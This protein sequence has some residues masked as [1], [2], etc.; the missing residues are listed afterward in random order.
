M[1]H[2]KVKPVRIP[3]LEE[4][5]KERE[6]L[7]YKERYHKVFRST[8]YSLVVVAAIAVLLATLFLPVLK[9]SGDSMAPTLTDQDI[10]LLIKTNHYD[11][12]DLCSFSWQNKLLV[13]R[14]IGKPGDVIDIDEKGIVS[15]NGQTINEPY[16]DELALG[17]CDISF[18][19]QVPE[20]KYFVLGDHRSVSIDSRN[21]AIGCIEKDQII[22]KIFLRIWPLNR[23]SFMG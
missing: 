11:I 23:I 3:S 8:V 9:I 14:I 15:V 16:V 10:L 2:N 6:R 17:E 22:G 13:K 12:G 1:K 19:Y 21:S 5:T 20:N 7:I 4:I 18:P